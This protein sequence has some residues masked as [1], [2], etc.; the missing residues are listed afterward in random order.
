MDHEGETERTERGGTE[1]PS[2]TELLAFAQKT[3]AINTDVPIG[4]LLEHAA[5][6]DRGQLN[7]VAVAWSKY[8]AVL[9]C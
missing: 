5:V 9:P 4:T 3:N 2:P 1:R 7:I 8:V 6:L